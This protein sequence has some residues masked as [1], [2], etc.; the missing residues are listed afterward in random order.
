MILLLGPEDINGL[1][2]IKEAV[3]AMEQGLRDWANNPEL[4]A[5]R[6]RVHAPSGA[7]VTVHQG[8][9]ASSHGIGL[10]TFRMDHDL[11]AMG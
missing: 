4:S 6:R 1:V 2:T 3:D 10:I 7:R 5:L 11:L 9:P 8:A